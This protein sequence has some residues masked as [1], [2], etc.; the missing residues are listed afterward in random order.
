[1]YHRF[2][3]SLCLIFFSLVAS[4]QIKFPD[5]ESGYMQQ[6][7]AMIQTA[8]NEKSSLAFQEF[9]NA[10]NA[11]NFSA[12]NKKNIIKISQV[13]AKKRL[14]TSTHFTSFYSF[15]YSAV[16]KRNMSTGDLDSLLLVTSKVLDKCDPKDVNSFFSNTAIFLDSYK[17]YSS[18]YN[19]LVVGGGSFKF[20]FAEEAPVKVEE[21]APAD[22]A[23]GDGHFD[24]WDNQQKVEDEWGSS[25]DAWGDE[26]PVAGS[27][28]APAAAPVNTFDVGYSPPAQPLVAG[29]VIEFTDSDLA[30]V[31]AHDSTVIRKTSG[32]F[33]IHKNLFVG[34]GGT[35]DWTTAGYTPEQIYVELKDYNFNVNSPRIS[36]EPV[37]LH[38]PERCDS[39]VQGVF[40][41]ASKK[42]TGAKQYPRFKSFASNI[43]VKGLDENIEYY[44]GLALEG[45]R[46]YS[47]SV[48]EGKAKLLI[49]R[50]GEVKVKAVANRIEISDSI[51]IGN[52]ASIVIY[53]DQDSIY[54][55]AANLQFTKANSTLRLTKSPG[56]RNTP[57]IDTYH[58]MEIVVDALIWNLDSS[59]IEFSITNAATELPALF[60][61]KEFFEAGK[62]SLLQ[63][64]YRFHPLQMIVGYAENIKKKTK[65]TTFAP[66]T[67][68]DLAKA[69]NFEEITIRG[70]MT[71]MMK[72]GF[73]DYD[74]RTTE[75]KLREK[76]I[77]YVLSRRDKKD[78]DNFSFKAIEPSGRNATLDLETK[79]LIVRGVDKVSVMDSLSIFIIPEN[80]TLVIRE[81]RGFGFD[82]KINTANFQFVGKKF[83]FNY[84]SF[85][86]HMPEIDAIKMAASD[87]S[88]KEKGA[89]KTRVLS[90]ELRYSS[91]TLY[92]N[93]P[94]NKSGRVRYPEYPIFN[95][96]KGASV[97][98]NKKEIAGG[99]YDTSIQFKIPPFTV[100]SLANS[101]PQSI[102]FDGEF[103]SGGILPKFKTKLVVMPDFS[104]GFDYKVP[105]DGF[106]L[107]E[108]KGKFFN[109]VTMDNRG[110]TGNGHIKYLNT[111][112]YSNEF[113]FFKDSVLTIGTNADTKAG[114]NP[115][116]AQ[117]VLFPEFSVGEYELNWQAKKDSMMITNS[118]APIQLYK[119]TATLNGTGII[120]EEGMFGSGV[121]ETRG[122]L[123][124]SH[125]F[126]FEEKKYFGRN[127]TFTV[128]SDNPAKPAFKSSD[129]HLQFD[130][131]KEVAEFSPEVS[132]FASTEFPYL[133]YK[134]SIEKG[135]WDMK[136]RKVVLKTEG[137]DISKSYFYS[138]HPFQDSLV[139]NARA[140]IYDMESQSLKIEGVPFIK[141]MD[142]K[143]FAD[144]NKV[145]I[146]E[147]AVMETLKNSKAQFDTVNA[148]HNL[149][150]G[151][152]DIKGRFKLKGTATYDYKNS[153]G[154]HYSFVF[155][156][157]TFSE[158]VDLKKS[159][160]K[161][162]KDQVVQED[163]QSLLNKENGLE[164]DNQTVEQEQQD[165]SLGT[166]TSLVKDT[167]SGD[168]T[169]ETSGTTNKK[170]VKES[171]KTKSKKKKE[172]KGKKGKKK[173]KGKKGSDKG[174]ELESD[175]T[176]IPMQVLN[177]VIKK[178]ADPTNKHTVAV[179]LI[180]PEDSIELAKKI[181]Y[182]GKV[183]MYSDL[184][185]LFFNGFVKL[186]LKG[187]LS[188]SQWL[189]YKND[190]DTSD[191]KILLEDPR[192]DNG[193]KLTTGLH[194]NRDFDL[195]TTFISE[196]D[197][198]SDFDV[199][200]SKGI[201]KFNSHPDSSVFTVCSEEKFKDPTG[202]AGNLLEYDDNASTIAY[203]GRFNFVQ[204]N[205]G[206]N[207]LA[208]GSGKA[209]IDSS[210]YDFNNIMVFNFTMHKSIPDA[211]AQNLTA[212]ADAIP[213]DS[214]E[215]IQDP[216]IL[217]AME[218][219]YEQKV[220]EFIGTK[221]YNSTRSKTAIPTIPLY[222]LSSDF[223]E[224]IVLSDVNLK[225]SNKHKAFYS[226]GK[227]KVS[228]VKKTLVDKVMTGYVEI[229]KSFT[230][231]VV[232]L[233]LEPTEGNWYFFTFDDN[234]LAVTT[235]NDE[236]NAVIAKKSKGEQETRDKLF[237]VQAEA[238]EKNQFQTAFL[239]KYL[240][241]VEE[242]YTPDR[243]PK[244]S[245]QP[246]EELEIQE[247][248][249]PELPAEEEIQQEE[250]PS[251]PVKKNNEG[252]VI[253]EPE[254]N[255]GPKEHSVDEKKKLQ[256][257]R[258]R[259]KDMLK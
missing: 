212:I 131:E 20:R 115:Q 217:D 58:Q 226:V 146:R 47:S 13:M 68:A 162:D 164:Q 61:S 7:S 186:D 84:D 169:E 118:T 10:W 40:E 38:Y 167:P 64:I 197:S 220:L 128:K 230:G 166:E 96:D 138:T 127:T 257:E 205:E 117:T 105:E 187:A 145:V 43:P 135:I 129:C 132:G 254:L 41:F 152:F 168:Q 97:L 171:K 223:S 70:A 112:C 221:A 14:R 26:T 95:A 247:E 12:S 21:P 240:G 122:S 207:V 39:V 174:N 116:I 6:A 204:K 250:V 210:F 198:A 252:T 163:I 150:N 45:R 203:R 33:M 57:F 109:K 225:W 28:G 15:L 62:Y 90:N 31:T 121:L 147:N 235:S 74:T 34:K 193:N 37:L 165:P 27:E 183:T 255:R 228:N 91:G 227:V 81:N 190:G 248:P 100:D 89:A 124:A 232:T 239:E 71:A 83:E 46:L 125:N 78:Y 156:N 140:G 151:T 113:H 215:M 144:S 236:I 42:T 157:Y 99:V 1:M 148:Y 243:E 224:G 67:T 245:E 16:A 5:D 55:P 52:I 49:K 50:K 136:T 246:V 86:V 94:D 130:L 141:V 175:T 154:D 19:Q 199:F 53:Q 211:I 103:Q 244:S 231:D 72:Q 69:Y 173:K 119:N 108:G 8:K 180:Y 179:G 214:S 202:Y 48:D 238:M 216:A 120:T 126:Y 60:E 23:S 188:Y 87:T 101:D 155:K 51:F 139:F 184:K 253:E 114:K 160:R 9:S 234:R 161:K 192:A 249:E 93:K 201:L 35:F 159:N 209:I 158:K 30:M 208:G 32:S 206:V 182:K 191:V 196:K 242:G 11:G 2:I 4:A 106:Q 65:D 92:I 251:E 44:G 110:L 153:S 172:K 104:L 24:D 3:L 59:K 177:P 181:L 133:K 66:F 233:L 259:L 63:G 142:G 194:I 77:H 22:S 170:K 143:I 237:F 75:I 17:I 213:A 176:R 29:P 149:Y 178:E 256:E 222:E 98:F 25:Y 137:E 102:G 107:Y 18:S 218:R 88:I 73:I 134:T 123:S 219:R 200:T 111:T 54:H 76:A 229:K 56:Y 185:E 85:L 80:K 82:G 36:A 195:Y 189:A 258:Q 241:I 79:D